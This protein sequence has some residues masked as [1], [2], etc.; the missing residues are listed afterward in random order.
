MGLSSF[1]ES[2]NKDFI[3]LERPVIFPQKG[4][5]QPGN[6]SPAILKEW[7]LVTSLALVY[8]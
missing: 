3:P 5:G 1:K 8:W 6:V 4:T 2:V 7:E